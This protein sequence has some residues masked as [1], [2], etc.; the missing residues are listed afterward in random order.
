LP[1]VAKHVLILGAGFGG[2]ASANLL[3]KSLSRKEC[4]I[5]V[6]DKKQHFIMGILNLWIL[7]GTR[8]LED[9][10]V[11]LNKLEDKGISFLNEEI[12]DID[13]ARSNITLRTTDNKLEYDYLIVALGAEL[14]PKLIDGYQDDQRCFNV[15]DPHQVANL[16]DKILSLKS[17]RIVICIV[18]VPYK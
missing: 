4:R 11:A 17:G 2:L 16:R 9:S 10:R 5:T 12:T 15:Y 14:A 18:A 1:T 7:S 8:R 6:V 3:R 13:T